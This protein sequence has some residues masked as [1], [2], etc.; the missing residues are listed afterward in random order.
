MEVDT[1]LTAIGES[2][3]LSF[4]SEEINTEWGSII[5]DGFC[6]TSQTR[7]FAGGDVIDQPRTVAHAIGSGKKAAIAIDTFLRTADIKTAI[8]PTTVGDK[9]SISMQ[10]YL[11]GDFRFDG[12]KVVRFEDLNTAYFEPAHQVTLP[13][14]SLEE[15]KGSFAEVNTGL[16]E[17]TVLR[18]SG[19]CF[20]CGVCNMCENCWVFCPDIS[21]WP[22]KDAFGYDIDYDH[23]K[24]CGICVEECPRAAMSMEEEIK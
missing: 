10:R 21:I 3:E 4:L 2:P 1:I 17:E 15:A 11:H 5:T 24:G 19:R 6:A 23:C 22:K 9:D 8:Q 12:S 20:N 13:R 18:E 16:D 14:L 7:I